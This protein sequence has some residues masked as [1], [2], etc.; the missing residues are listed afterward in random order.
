MIA[1]VLRLLAAVVYVVC[2]LL[3]TCVEENLGGSQKGK[4]IFFLILY[5]HL[6]SFSGVWHCFRAQIFVLLFFFFT[7]VR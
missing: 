3:L 7:I 1:R 6:Q 4:A 2:K 5:V